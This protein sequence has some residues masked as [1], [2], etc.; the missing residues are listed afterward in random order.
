MLSEQNQNKFDALDVVC[1]VS[2]NLD[3]SFRMSQIFEGKEYD[4]SKCY[5]VVDPST[6]E[7]IATWELGAVI[8]GEGK[9]AKSLQFYKSYLLCESK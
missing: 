3:G 5:K 7:I 6:K 4:E 9:E 2:M 1:S 8:M